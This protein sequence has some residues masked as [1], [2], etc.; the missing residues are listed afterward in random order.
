MTLSL[1]LPPL[2]KKGDIVAAVS[3][4]WAG[5][6]VYPH[7]YEIGKRQF[8]ETF[9]LKVIEM[10][11]TLDSV[12]ELDKNPKARADD[13]NAA[14]KN[15]DIKAIITT[16]GGDDCV[17]LLPYL[18]YRAI[19]ENPKFFIGYSDPTALHFAF[20]KAGV[21]SVYGP[22]FLTTFAENCGILD[23]VKNSL[24]DIL[25]NGN[26]QGEICPSEFWINEFLD[27]GNPDNQKKKRK[28]IKNEGYRFL[29]GKKT[30]QGQLIG[31]C[32][33][34]LEM[35]K[36]T[37][38]WP[39]ETVWEDCILFIDLSEEAPSPTYVIRCLRNYAAAGI[40]KRLKG[41]LV[42]R[43]CNVPTADFNKYDEA[44]VHAV[45]DEAGLDIPIVTRMDFG[46]TDPIC[47]LPY[48][49]LAEINPA[50]KTVSL[51]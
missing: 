6:S 32:L 44:F 36:A 9:G 23:Y 16:I 42:G 43:P 5:A 48:G 45:R 29:L 51:L 14:V 4:S 1:K 13:I 24:N 2:L 33:E 30:V 11:H 3:S 17:R 27:W 28:R 31:G 40:L 50:E 25:F 35:I 39:D 26:T 20:L 47:C 18:D 19:A 21:S 34:V 15:P 37:P 10:P 41:I 46:H 22:A 8:E 7:R 49:A 38:V 12:E